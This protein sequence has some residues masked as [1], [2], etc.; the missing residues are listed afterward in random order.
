MG[1][2]DN[3]FM[4]G[5]MQAAIPV[6]VKR[7]LMNH[8]LGHEGRAVAVTANLGP[9]AEAVGKDRLVPLQLA[10]NGFDIRVKQQFS[11]IAA[12]TVRRIPRAVDPETIALARLDSGQVDAGLDAIFIEETKFD[13]LGN[14]GK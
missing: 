10:I 7:G 6:P 11:R 12:V 5:Q 14:S 2:I 8:A 1:F 3:G 13:T 4:P 9:G